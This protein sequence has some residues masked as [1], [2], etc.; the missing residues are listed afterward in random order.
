[1]QLLHSLLKARH[2]LRLKN[3]E[4]VLVVHE[5]LNQERGIISARFRSR[6]GQVIEWPLGPLWHRHMLEAFFL[7]LE[8]EAGKRK[9]VQH[10]R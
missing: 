5:G 1:M 8:T 2:E 3:L 4:D 7:E 6:D 9:L 10:V